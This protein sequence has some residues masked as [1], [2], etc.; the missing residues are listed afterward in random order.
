M[1]KNEKRT[2]NY[3]IDFM[4]FIFIIF[5]FI[6]H[7]TPF[8]KSNTSFVIPHA[9]GW[10]AV[11]FFFIVS[12]FFMILSYERRGEEQKLNPGY[13][14]FVFVINKLKSLA[15]PFLTSFF[16]GVIIYIYINGFN[17]SIIKTLPELLF[18]NRIGIDSLVINGS[19][20]Y[21]SAMLI[22]MLPLYYI[23]AKNKDYYIYVFSPIVALLSYGYIYHFDMP[24]QNNSLYLNIL[25]VGVFRAINGICVGAIT[26]LICNKIKEIITTKRQKVLLTFLEIILYLII[27]ITWFNTND[28]KI[29][30][31]VMLLLPI[32]LGITFSQK[33]YISILFKSSKFEVIKSISLAIFFNHW[34]ARVIVKTYF[35][36]ERYRTCVLLM[37]LITFI[38][39]I[40]Y[41]LIIKLSKLLYKKIIHY[42]DFEQKT[43]RMN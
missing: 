6:S 15:T 19:T 5:V 24:Y 8:L 11:F 18:I 20:W 1:A 16:I 23:L 35:I 2:K 41:V 38:I 22:A 37:I 14:A 13:S 27:F 34:S 39:S 17:I 42:F 3:Q 25:T 36:N 29:V 31:S 4:K 30:F 10:W 28:Y 40:F 12:G 26:Y 32:A 43:T 21:I 9:I 33:S 7:T